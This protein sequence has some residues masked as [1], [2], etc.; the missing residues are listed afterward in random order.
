MN[1][2]ITSAIALAD[3]LEYEK[4]L[5]SDACK[6]VLKHLENKNYDI[7]EINKELV[8]KCGIKLGER[9]KR[10]EKIFVNEQ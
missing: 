8:E 3:S 9:G 1:L 6:I 4:E 10:H 7:E 5:S 2:F